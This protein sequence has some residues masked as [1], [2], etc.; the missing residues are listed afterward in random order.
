MAENNQEIKIETLSYSE[1]ILLINDKYL[2]LFNEF[3]EKFKYH[4]E[5]IGS[6]QMI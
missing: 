5:L 4:D 2:L 6:L 3:I 1:S